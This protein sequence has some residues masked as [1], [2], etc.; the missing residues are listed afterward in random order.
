MPCMVL[1]TI[2]FVSLVLAEILWP[3][4][5][6][7]KWALSGACFLICMIVAYRLSLRHKKEIENLTAL[8]RASV[9]SPPGADPHI[10]KWAAEIYAFVS[11]QFFKLNQQVLEAQE[12]LA[13]LRTECEEHSRFK[14]DVEKH[15]GLLAERVQTLAVICGDAA[16][17]LS[18]E[19]HRMAQMVAEVNHGVEVQKHGL[20]ET[21]EAVTSASNSIEQVFSGVAF[22]SENAG[23]SR[24]LAYDGQNEVREAA[25]T[26]RGV[27]DVT[28]QLQGEL[29]T[30][31]S[32]FEN[33]AHVM[34]KI[35]EVADHSNL[36]ALNAAIE[37]ARAG[38]AGRGFAVVAE[39]VQKLSQNTM[40]A[41]REISELVEE[42]RGTVSAGV[43]GMEAAQLQIAQS[44]ERAE[45]ADGLM[46]EIT[47][48]MDEAA[49]SLS[50]IGAA[51]DTQKDSGFR[52]RSAMEAINTV[53]ES[54]SRMMQSFTI[55]LVQVAG[56]IED[57]HGISDAL[58]G[59]DLEINESSRLVEWS[60]DLETG[61][62]L[63]DSQHKMLCAYINALHRAAEKNHGGQAIME[64]VG[65]LKAYTSTH[66]ST[67]EQYF[68]HS[69][70]PDTEKHKQIHR[71][72][73]ETVT[74][75]ERNLVNGATS[76][77]DELL[78]FLK[79]WL[80]NHIKGTDQQFV[81][82]VFEAAGKEH[83]HSVSPGGGTGAHRNAGRQ[84]PGFASR[85]LPSNSPSSHLAGADSPPPHG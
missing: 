3:V 26:V 69:A 11:T 74:E 66:F 82:F 49:S 6:P 25:C 54:S 71:R 20:L 21:A 63:I 15:N 14:S 58:K 72:F 85:Q 70:Y 46:E 60:Q 76:V 52:T 9:D 8:L 31:D 10:A 51:A 33:I 50:V 42:M 78:V 32:Q 1:L 59:G 53:M 5:M 38:E 47:Q 2:L 48:A 61:I 81:S 43:R 83:P 56:A 55:G 84:Q 39:E 64:I 79:N 4:S 80:L 68:S 13:L 34:N 40:Q 18:H 22:A 27:Q 67:E 35:G 12:A 16:E 62:E 77:N 36:L 75:V 19:L 37:A 30:L 17:E 57:L 44:V 28:A 41:S 24:R 7:A 23:S 65:C 73:V 29:R 45:K